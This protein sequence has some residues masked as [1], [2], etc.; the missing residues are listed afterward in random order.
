VAVHDHDHHSHEHETTG[1]LSAKGDGVRILAID[2]GA[3]TQDV[4]LYDSARTPEN[5]FKLVLPSQTQI[6]GARIRRVTAERKPLHL[7]GTLMGGGAS[8]DAVRDHLAAGLPVTATES[9]ARTIHN[10]LERVRTLGVELSDEPPAGAVEVELGDLDL[11]GLA[12]ALAPFGVALPE[13]VAVAVQDHGYR[14]G[15]GN[16]AVR[17]EYLQGLVEGGG[18]LAS[19][20][21]HQPPAGM[22]RMAAVV[23][24]VPGAYVMDTGVAAVLGSLGDPVVARAVRDKGAILVNIGNMHTFATL[25]KGTRLFGLFEHHTGG[26]TAEIIHDLVEQLRAGTIDGATFTQQFD[27]HGAAL[28]DDYRREGPF[29]FVAVTGPNRQIARPLGY[30]E[31]APHGDMMLA[32]SFGL[33]EGV[34]MSLAAEGRATGLSLIVD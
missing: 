28:V 14:P 4:L 22:T 24:R 18:A 20:I 31:A 32:G 25:V 17:F 15:S 12:H 5:C 10:D 6:A 34:L 30:H 13:I 7:T 16:N 29:R 1:D 2:V 23:E 21:F 9:A 27:G 3:G 8:T 19:T 11:D 26:I 33:V